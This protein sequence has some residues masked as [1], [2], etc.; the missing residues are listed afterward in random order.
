MIKNIIFAGAG[1][2][3]WAYIGTIK[4]LNECINFNEIEHII[5]VSIGSVFGFCY[6]LG[7]DSEYLLDFFMDLNIKEYLDIDLDSILINQSLL[8]GNKLID[9]IR[10]LISIKI[11]PDVTFRDLY[12]YSKIKFTTN[13]LNITDSK[14]E[15]FNHELTPEI[16]VV[17]A[18]RASCSLPLL[19]P[20]YLLNGCHYF[21]GGLCNNCPIDFVDELFTIAFDAGYYSSKNSSNIKLFDLLNSF[22]SIANKQHNDNT[23]VKVYLILDS[24]FKDQLFNLNQSRDDIFN[25]YMNGY[26]NSKNILFKNHFSLSS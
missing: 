3:G 22:I 9:I 19:F 5:G 26:I 25:I 24:R 17:D 10:E 6:L 15:Y 23:S 8:I 21:D 20:S 18:I 7:M 13:A 2:K 4:A 11:D 1:F 16:K 12:H 14:L